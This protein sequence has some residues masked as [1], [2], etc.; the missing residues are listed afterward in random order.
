MSDEIV[1]EAP[2]YCPYCDEVIEDETPYD[3]TYQHQD[4]APHTYL[5]QEEFEEVDDCE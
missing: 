2:F 3:H 4:I 1:D 5:V